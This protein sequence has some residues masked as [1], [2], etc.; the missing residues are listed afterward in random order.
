MKILVRAFMVAL[1]VWGAAPMAQPFIE[2]A[3]LVYTLA[4]AE[5]PVARQTRPL[6][7]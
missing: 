3:W 5:P 1:V 7:L 2:R 4:T 6:D